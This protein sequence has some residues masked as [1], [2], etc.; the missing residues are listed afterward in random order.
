MPFVK[1]ES[2][3][4]SG[5]PLGARNKAT[6][7]LETMLTASG[8]ELTRGLIGRAP[9]GDRTALRLCLDRVLP[10]GPDRPVLFALPPVKTGAEAREVVGTIL[11]ATGAG[12]PHPAR[13]Q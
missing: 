2:G 3:N 6:V 5:R 8:E 11:V 7:V 4:S 9:G 1:G 12:G 13:S 10:R